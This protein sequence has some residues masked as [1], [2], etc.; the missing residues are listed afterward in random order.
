[1]VSRAAATPLTGAGSVC[2]AAG[3]FVLVRGLHWLEPAALDPCGLRGRR[4]AP[5]AA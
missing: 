4:G 1:L 5:M 3:C 2:T